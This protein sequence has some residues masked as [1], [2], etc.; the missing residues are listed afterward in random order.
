MKKIFILLAIMLIPSSA[1]AAVQMKVTA[2][3]EFHT[4]TPADSMNVKVREGIKLGDYD[5]K[6]GDTLKC[7]IQKIVDP[8]RGKRNA[9]FYVKPVSYT[10]E[11]TVNKINDDYY[12]KYSKTVL[13]KEELKKIPPG[14]VIKKA[15]LT[16]GSHFVK[17][18]STGVA[19]A[20]GVIQNDEDNRLKSG[21]VEAYK[22]SPLSYIDKGENLD[23]MPG[24]DFYLVFKIDDEQE[25]DKP[26]YTYTV[27]EEQD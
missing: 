9:V 21:V 16:V 6:Q 3:T 11:G 12:G 1:F 23:I 7:S 26:N 5:L 20:Q 10:S 17:G 19:F 8:K 24:D 13:S 18:L 25:E 22:E 4:E 2:L 14:K 27:P 15:A